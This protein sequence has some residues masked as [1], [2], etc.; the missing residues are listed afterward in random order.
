MKSLIYLSHNNS[1][2][3][4][5][6]S[7]LVD[8]FKIKNKSY[9]ITG[10]LLERHGIFIQYLEGPVASVDCLI[11]HIKQDKRH[12]VQFT[13]EQK[14]KKRRFPEWSMHL[15]NTGTQVEE[16]LYSKLLKRLVKAKRSYRSRWRVFFHTF[17]VKKV[18]K[19]ID[20]LAA[21]TVLDDVTAPKDTFR[22]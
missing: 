10:C 17:C 9:G 8:R 1:M 7:F 15:L 12:S 16:V 4:D 5:E 6:L 14:V 2:M 19:A 18:W 3:Q 21:V 20:T 13:L 22:Y 11:N